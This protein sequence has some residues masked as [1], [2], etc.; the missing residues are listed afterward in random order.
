MLKYYDGICIKLK[1]SLTEGCR[2][3]G[4]DCTAANGE[5]PLKLILW[6]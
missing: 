3:P 4:K 1:P 2:N 5:I 6:F